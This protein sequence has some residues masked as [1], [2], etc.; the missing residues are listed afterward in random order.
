MDED[1]VNGNEIGKEE[2]NFNEICNN[3]DETKHI[4]SPVSTAS[5]IVK[6]AS[7]TAANTNKVTEEAR[8]S[9]RLI[10]W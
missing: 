4:V 8:Q 7:N 3:N 1:I 6:K 2:E 9:T 10:V 5:N